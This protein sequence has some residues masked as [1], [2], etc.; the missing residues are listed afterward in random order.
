MVEKKESSS[1][2]LGEFRPY[3]RVMM[4]MITRIMIIVLTMMITIIK[5]HRTNCYLII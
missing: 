1:G 5:V 2:H 4:M 3:T